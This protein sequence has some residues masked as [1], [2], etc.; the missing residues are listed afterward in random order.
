MM[1]ATLAIFLIVALIISSIYG[2]L[3][4]YRKKKLQ[5]QQKSE[6]VQVNSNHK[7][8]TN[9]GGQHEVFAEKEV[10][11]IKNPLVENQDKNLNANAANIDHDIKIFVD[12]PTA[13]D[14]EK[15]IGLLETNFPEI[16]DDVSIDVLFPTPS[17]ST[18]SKW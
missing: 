2:Y 13:S 7:I 4:I 1:F 9:A 15:P 12:A 8:E 11:D 10:Q 3:S 14:S 6:H 18:V 16:E 17:P 5:Q